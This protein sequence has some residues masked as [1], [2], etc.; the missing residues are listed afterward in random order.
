MLRAE[1]SHNIYSPFCI[2]VS[3]DSTTVVSYINK[4]GEH[5]LPIYA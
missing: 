2:M 5:I 1:K 4:Q 3:T